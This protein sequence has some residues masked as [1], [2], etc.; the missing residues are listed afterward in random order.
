MRIFALVVLCFATAAAVPYNPHRRIDGTLASITQYPSLVALLY[1]YEWSVYIQECAGVI[2]NHRSILTAAH[3]PYF[4]A[5]PKWRVRVGSNWPTSGGQVHGVNGIIIHPLYRP[6]S[7][8][9][10]LAL[11]RVSADIHFDN[12]A[13]PAWIPTSRYFVP[14]NDPLWVAGWGADSYGALTGSQQLRHIQVQR[15]NH[16][17]CKNRYAFRKIPVTDN[18]ICSGWVTGGRDQC[19]G[20]SGGPVYHNSAVVGIWSF[21]LECSRPSDF[22]SV[23]TLV[24][25]YHTWILSNS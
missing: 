4:D 19:Q 24:G 7:L 2:V 16:I 6:N 18:M 12:Y 15:I 25:R 17:N 21:G 22:P 5:V 20:D 3:C 9:H 13:Q 23:N 10:D 11:L 14:D 8:D 1:A